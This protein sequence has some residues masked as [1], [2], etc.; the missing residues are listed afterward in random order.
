MINLGWVGSKALGAVV[1]ALVC[2]VAEP[3][4]AAC[5]DTVLDIGEDCDDGNFDDGDCCSSACSFEAAD[6]PC[7]SDGIACTN[8]VCDGA[9]VCSH[10]YEPRPTCFNASG[11]LSIKNVAG[12]DDDQFSLSLSNAPAAIPEDFGDPTGTDSYAACI[13]DMNGLVAEVNVAGGG[14]CDGKSCWKATKK[15]FQLKDKEGNNDGIRTLVMKASDKA[16]TQVKI[17]GKG[18]RLEDPTLSLEAPV[19]AQLVN[20]ATGQCYGTAFAEPGAIKKSTAE[21]FRAKT[22]YPPTF[23]KM[24]RK[25]YDPGKAPVLAP[26]GDGSRAAPNPSEVYVQSISYGGSGCPQGSIGTSLSNDRS[27]FTLIFDQFVAASGPGVSVTESR[28]N[29]Q[30]NINMR[31]P[32][33]WTYTISTIDYRGYVQIPAG[34]TAE[35]KSVYYFQGQTMQA[36]GATQFRGPATK[37]YLVRDTVPLNSLVWMPCSR[38]VPLNVNAQIRLIGPAGQNAQITT[39]SIDGKIK[40]VIGLQWR[41]C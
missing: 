2:C 13:Y 28:K 21:V 41:P 23:A 37:D 4:W 14:I 33:G 8:D 9:G 39:D 3:V 1:L 17:Q 31:V 38:V 6:S 20:V 5:G 7:T 24:K 12:G 18:T 32:N 26:Q 11:K 27:T 10:L 40:H 34:Y 19:A 15:G 29:C 25:E 36:S 30:I 22:K 16:K 35:Q